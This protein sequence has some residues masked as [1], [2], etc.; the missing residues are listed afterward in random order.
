MFCPVC[1]KFHRLDGARS[2]ICG[3][4]H[5]GSTEAAELGKVRV[6]PIVEPERWLYLNAL[7]SDDED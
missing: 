7:F 6:V 1:R 2:S 4:A 3:P 5:S